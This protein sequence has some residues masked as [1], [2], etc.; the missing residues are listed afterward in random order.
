M[1]STYHNMAMTYADNG[2]WSKAGHYYDR[3][4][5]LARELGDAQ[6]QAMVKLNRVELYLA[7]KD[8]PLAEAM[9]RQALQT[10]LSLQ[11]HLGEADAL[12]MLGVIHTRRKEWPRAKSCFTKSIKLSRD[13]HSPL[14]QA[15]AHYEYG[16]MLSRK[17]SKKAAI[18]QLRQAIDLFMSLKA[19]K[20]IE[21]AETELKR[22]LR[23]K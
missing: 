13:Y 18:K 12:K 19:V 16:C 23:I 20:E 8:L 22:I 4:Y 15:E 3:S 5:Q 21:K 14:S 2:N 6:L 10:Y 1:A 11:D 9:C 17:G 7:I